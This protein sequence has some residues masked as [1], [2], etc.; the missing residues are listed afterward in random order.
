MAVFGRKEKRARVIVRNKKPIGGAH[1]YG[2]P[3]S[4]VDPLDPTRFTWVEFQYAER[5]EH[6]HPDDT[7]LLLKC[8]VEVY[9]AL[10]EGMRGTAV[11]TGSGMGK[12]LVAFAEEGEE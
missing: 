11:W 4:V 12:R 8:P 10:R 3:T 2:H 6:H 5:R 1:F 7:Y 9:D